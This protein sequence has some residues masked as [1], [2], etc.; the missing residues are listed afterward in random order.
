[1]KQ[2]NR[3][4]VKEPQWNTFLQMV[5]R[6][7][8]VLIRHARFLTHHN[9]DKAQDLMQETILRA[10]GAFHAGKF[11]EGFKLCAWLARILTNYF[12]NDYRREK[13]WEAGVTVDELTAGGIGG[14]T[15]THISE[16]PEILLMHQTFDEPIEQALAELSDNLRVTILLVDVQEYS[17]QEAAEVLNVPVGTV[18]SRLARARFQLRGS[19]QSYAE[20]RNVA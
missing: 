8:T 13:K 17:Y 20:K 5:Q 12:L 4:E 11:L 14:P 3:N 16:T 2:T 10:Y 7:E 15:Q 19:L 6:C 18:R 1:V 9:E